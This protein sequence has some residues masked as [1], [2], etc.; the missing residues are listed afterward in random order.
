MS[1]LKKG[2]DVLGEEDLSSTRR[3]DTVCTSIEEN[4]GEGF[5]LRRSQ[6]LLAG[7][8]QSAACEQFV[9][10]I[11]VLISEEFIRGRHRSWQEPSVRSNFKLPDRTN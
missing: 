6:L 4:P 10:Q 11:E 9:R 7:E 3:N 1:L 5:S 8:K 2:V